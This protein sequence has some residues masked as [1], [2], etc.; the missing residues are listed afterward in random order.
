[1]QFRGKSLSYVHSS[2]PAQLLNSG[3]WN[4]ARGSGQRKNMLLKISTL[5]ALLLG[6]ALASEHQLSRVRRGTRRLNIISRSSCLDHT[7]LHVYLED[8]TWLQLDGRWAK[9]CRCSRS[10]IRCHSVPVQDCPKNMCYNGGKCQQALYSAHQVCKCQSGY[11]GPLCEI[12]TKER[13][14]R[15]RGTS[16]RGTW[17]RTVSGKQCLNWN[18]RAVALSHYNGHA[19]NAQQWGLGNH[20]FCRNPDNDSVPWCHVYNGHVISW[21][22]CSLPACP[23]KFKDE[24]YISNGASYRGT[25]DYSQS[26]QPCISWDSELL[27]HRAYN[28]W[29]PDAHRLGLGSHNYCRN[30]NGSPEPWCHVKGRRGVTVESCDIKHCNPEEET[31]GRRDP[32]LQQFR[33]KGGA[34]VDITSHPWQAAV[35][36]YD[37]RGKDLLFQFGGSLIA[38]CWV[39]T[40]AHC[41]QDKQKPQ[42]LRVVLG[43]TKV[44]EP[45]VGEQILEVEEYFVHKGYSEDTFN[46]D[47]ALIKL[48]SKNGRCAKMTR[49]VRTVCLPQ[50]GQRL[51]DWMECQISGYGRLQPFD[52]KF[53][54]KLKEG[55][56]RLYPANKCTPDQLDNRNVTENMICAGNTQGTNDDACKGDSGGPLV[57]E[58]KGQ[59]SLQGIISW[60][61][62]CG[63]KGVPGVY[64]KVVNYLEWIRDHMSKPSLPYFKNLNRRE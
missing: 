8:E 14:Y 62:S 11:K 12:D 5:I 31:C 2:E 25:K 4:T 6:L 3:N 48:R 61:I 63:K 26:G 38:S 13:C 18:M 24:C 52:H 56:V 27:R 21:E 23:H 1:M 49:S 16:Y 60:G 46:N 45:T 33:I 22:K 37:K 34:F 42:E 55:N 30:P 58:A 64:T 10:E 32:M 28:T 36:Y 35:M 41:F 9:Y 54:S 57:C 17:S 44:K 50:K 47:I 40:A 59:M 20:N 19:T 39:L 15:G 51:A 7:N 29:V 43:R 53:A